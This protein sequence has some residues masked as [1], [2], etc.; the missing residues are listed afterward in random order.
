MSLG[1]QFSFTLSYLLFICSSP[2]L[3]VSAFLELLSDALFTLQYLPLLMLSFPHLFAVFLTFFHFPLTSSHV[4]SPFLTF[5]SVSYFFKE[6]FS[7]CF[8]LFVTFSHFLTLFETC[9]R[10]FSPSLSLFITFDHL[11]SLSWTLFTTAYHFYHFSY[12]FLSLSLQLFIMFC[13]FYHLLSLFITFYHFLSLLSLSI[14]FY[15]LPLSF[16]K[17]SH[18]RP[19]F[20]LGLCCL[21]LRP[22]RYIHSLSLC[23]R[24]KKKHD[25]PIAKLDVVCL[26]G[27]TR[28]LSHSISRTVLWISYNLT[29]KR[30]QKGNN[31]QSEKKW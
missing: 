7:L 19:S 4:F 31:E 23:H 20:S 27:K 25:P 28:K 5:S 18:H 11:L 8:S 13:H 9:P 3:T 12:H 16:V 26:G 15:R 29:T 17:K 2:F 14:H 22:P 24:R 1:L 10:S 30:L 6:C 21:F